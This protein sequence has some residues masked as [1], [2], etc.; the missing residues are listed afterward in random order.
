MVSLSNYNHRHVYILN[1]PSDCLMA[2]NAV[3]SVTI[4]AQSYPT[5]VTQAVTVLR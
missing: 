3:G 5:L 1:K 4:V 2:H